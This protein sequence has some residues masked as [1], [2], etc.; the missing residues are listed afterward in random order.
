[1]ESEKS[2][3]KYLIVFDFDQTIT[4]KDSIYELSNITLSKED[5]HKII[6]MDKSD[7]YDAY[8]YTYKRMKDIGLLKI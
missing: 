2:S 3:K 6:E 1:M 4:D 5:Y 8:N 7:Y